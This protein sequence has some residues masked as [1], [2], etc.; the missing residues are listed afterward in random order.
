MNKDNINTYISYISIF[1]IIIKAL[2]VILLAINNPGYIIPDMVY[3]TLMILPICLLFYSSKKKYSSVCLLGVI[4]SISIILSLE[5]FD[6]FYGILLMIFSLLLLP[7]INIY[8]DSY[9]KT[10]FKFL[11]SM[12]LLILIPYTVAI[13]M[14]EV[15]ANKY[16]DLGE[17]T[18][19]DNFKLAYNSVSNACDD[20][21]R[22]N[23]MLPTDGHGQIAFGLLSIDEPSLFKGQ[24]IWKYSYTTRGKTLF[25]LSEDSYL[26]KNGYD[27]LFN[28]IY[29]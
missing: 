3:Q 26:Y 5:V 4:L 8:R 24:G 21:Y 7:T 19:L 17:E 11:I 23:K 12:L 1:G 15:Q 9:K 28:K 13:N 6:I 2:E 18:V 14:Y 20:Y 29:N 16:E 22:K 10:R 25:V 27:K